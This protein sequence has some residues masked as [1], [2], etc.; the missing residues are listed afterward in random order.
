VS[1]AGAEFIGDMHKL[2]HICMTENHEV[3]NHDIIQNS[4]NSL[5]G[6]VFLPNA[7]T[8]HVFGP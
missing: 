3:Y 1:H 6:S 4:T 8:D 2:L 5:F 7:T